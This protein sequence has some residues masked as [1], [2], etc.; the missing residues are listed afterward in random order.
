MDDYLILSISM[1]AGR[2][3]SGCQFA[4]FVD[5]DRKSN[6]ILKVFDLLAERGLSEE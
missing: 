4:R 3:T 2:S 6:L 1:D 5:E